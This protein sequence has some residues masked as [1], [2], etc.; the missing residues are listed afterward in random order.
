MNYLKNYINYA[1]DSINKV[2][3]YMNGY[4]VKNKLKNILYY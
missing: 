3:G 1:D 2:S 4:Q